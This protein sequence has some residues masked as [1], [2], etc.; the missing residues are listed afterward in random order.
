MGFSSL[1][2]LSL[3][4]LLLFH[5]SLVEAQSIFRRHH[6]RQRSFR[7]VQQDECQ[8]DRINAMEPSRKVHSEAGVTELW[9]QNDQQFRCAGVVALRHVIRERGM[10]LPIYVNGP[11][12]VY[13]LQGNGIQGALKPGCPETFEYSESQSQPQFRQAGRQT[14]DDSHQQVRNIRRGDV[15]ALPHG[16]AH[17]VYN[18]GRTPLVLVQ[19]ID[20]GNQHNQLDQ[21]LRA[22]FIAG[23]LEEDISQRER[24]Q[25]YQSR[26]ESRSRG[27]Q[28]GR[29]SRNVFAGID[30]ELLAE[31]FNI[32]TDL[33]R[34]LKG[35]NDNRGIIVNV[36]GELEVLTPERSREEEQRER[37]EERRGGYSTSRP[38]RGYRGSGYANGIE[39]T[40]CMDTRLKRNID[41]PSASDV[42]NPQ[43]G[44]VTNVNSFNLP[45]LQ[46]LRLSAQKGVLYRNAVM[47]PHWNMNAHSIYYFTEG[48]GNVQIVDDNGEPVFDGQVREGQILIAPQNFVVIKEAREEGLEWVAF[49]T[50]DNAQIQQLAGRVSA[51]R[52]MPEDVVA[53]S[54]QISR[55]DARRVMFNR[56]E[57]TMFSPSIRS[58]FR[59]VE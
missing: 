32:N 19:I 3:C 48:S 20:L 5:S 12:L 51:L 55:E 43:A 57:V 37:E 31:A 16:V 59:R 46:H 28:R 47:A 38:Y 24:S 29:S 27:E 44:R 11:K 35:E 25:E 33:A 36:E 10:L 13:V 9:D 4:F 22:F 52:A 58:P 49:K 23:N 6:H 53:N 45:I 7:G 39:E 56:Q 41:R 8:L 18:N 40:I 21:D 54:Y 15:I 17:W 50:N 14:G 42:F 34:R 30:D 1:L 26:R 2:S